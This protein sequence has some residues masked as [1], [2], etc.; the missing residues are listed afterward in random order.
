[1]T[2]SHR[3]TRNYSSSVIP[4]RI[5]ELE[6]ELFEKRA[7]RPYDT[8]TGFGATPGAGAVVDTLMF[9]REV[10]LPANL[11]GSVG[12]IG[13]NPSASMVL[14]LR[15]DGVEIGTITISTTGVFTFATTGGT[16]KVIAAGSKVTLVGPATADTTAANADI[17]I[18]GEL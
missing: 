17:T 3:S 13:T 4:A 5:T 1:M 2:Y 18:A 16:E 11:T 10:T 9:A 14:S 7:V 6:D 15:D 8:Y 12:T